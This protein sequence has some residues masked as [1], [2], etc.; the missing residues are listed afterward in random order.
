[1]KLVANPPREAETTPPPDAG[2]APVEVKAPVDVR[3]LALTVIAGIAA[4][5]L[6]QYAQSVIIPVVLGILISYA[7]DPPVDRLAKLRVPRPVGAAL[8][9]LMTVTVCGLLVYGL[10]AQAGAVVEQLPRGARHIRQLIEGDRASTG[11]SAIEQV[12]K[13]ASE[14]EKA[15]DATAPTPTPAGVQRVRIDPPPFSVS[16]YVMWG[17]IGL[18]G[19]LG[20]CVLILFLTYFLLASG[21]LYRRKL[22]RIAGPSLTQKKVTV[23][24]LSEIDRQIEWFLLVQVFSSTVVAVASWLA[25][26]A[27]GLQQAGLWGLLAGVFNSIPY[28]GPVVVTGATATVAFLQFGNVE[29]PV[30]VG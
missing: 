22:V 14:L 12:Q 27:L 4:I 5:M 21:D 29:M 30:L 6:L 7:L 26:R 3:N 2:G 18:L 10:Q 25:F 16:E 19:A 11:P 24:I 23:Q 15:A 20:Q 28:F 9:L 8:I 1:M 13:A 17:S